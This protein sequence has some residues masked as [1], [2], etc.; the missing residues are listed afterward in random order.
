MA[1]RYKL[2]PLRHLFRMKRT[3]RS[4]II[5]IRKKTFSYKNS[6]WFFDQA[7]QTFH[8][9][10]IFGKWWNAYLLCWVYCVLSAHEHWSISYR[11]PCVRKMKIF[12]DR[13]PDSTWTYNEHPSNIHLWTLDHPMDVRLK[14]AGHSM[15]IHLRYFNWTSIGHS[16]F[17]KRTSTEC[18]VCLKFE[19][20][21]N[22]NML[23][24]F[25]KN[26]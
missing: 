3:I 8:Y 16:N 12:Y 11:T 9:G 25:T 26:F 22:F 4:K 23:L 13:Y 14:S 21:T 18:T 20:I 19:L 7:I 24:V 2:C 6:A 17:D 10:V 1:Y 5:Q 15:D